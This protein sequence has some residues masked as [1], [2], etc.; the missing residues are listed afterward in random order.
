MKD[1]IESRNL[2]LSYTNK[3]KNIMILTLKWD[4]TFCQGCLVID[5][6]VAGAKT[7]IVAWCYNTVKYVQ[8]PHSHNSP[9]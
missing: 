6:M 7:R 5:E 9:W 2:R 3:I 4:M 8:C 1:L